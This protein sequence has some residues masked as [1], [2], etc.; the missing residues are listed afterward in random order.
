MFERHFTRFSTLVAEWAGSPMG[1]TLALTSIVLWA[2]LGPVTHY[3]DLWQLSINT[4]TTI[5][6]FLMVFLIQNSQNREG[7]A[8]QVKLDELLRAV[9]DAQNSFIGRSVLG[10]RNPSK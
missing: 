6:T 5:V 2:A 7:Q 4:G 1:F 9:K 3:S 8:L 10:G